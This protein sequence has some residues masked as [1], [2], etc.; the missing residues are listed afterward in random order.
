MPHRIRRG[1]GTAAFGRAIV[2]LL[3][4]RLVNV[5]DRYVLAV[6]AKGPA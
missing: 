1:L 2:R 4:Q 6:R 3:V 5:N